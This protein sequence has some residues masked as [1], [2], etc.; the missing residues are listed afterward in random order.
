MKGTHHAAIGYGFIRAVCSFAKKKQLY[1]EHVAN[2]R[3]AVKALA[4]QAKDLYFEREKVALPP[5]PGDDTRFVL[6]HFLDMTTDYE[7]TVIVKE[8]LDDCSE[9][10]HYLEQSF[11]VAHTEWRV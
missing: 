5:P 7:D 9:R 2:Y 3:K 4:H 8:E 1:N 6:M 10:L 11:G